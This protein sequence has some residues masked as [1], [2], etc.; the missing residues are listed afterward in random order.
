MQSSDD[1]QMDD[2]NFVLDSPYVNNVYKCT[3]LDE[4][5]F[6]SSYNN[7][8]KFSIMS[9]NIQSL[10][11]KFNDFAELI[12]SLNSHNSAP[13]V[14]CLQELWQFPDS[15]AFS[16][17]GY[18]PLEYKLRRNN[19][20]GGGV[21]IFI[22][23]RLKYSVL[24][25]KSIF[26]DRIFESL[27]IEVELGPSAKC[28]VGSTYRPGTKHP[29]LSSGDQ[30]TQFMDLLSNLCSNLS[31]YKS[32]VYSFGDFNLDLLQYNSS[33]QVTDYIDLLFSF[34][35]MQIITK[36]TR[37]TLKSA[38]L[39]DHLITTSDSNVFESVI[40]TTKLSDH[41]PLIYVSNSQTQEGSNEFYEA[42]NFSY[43]NLEAFGQILQR[44]D[45]N[46]TLTSDCPQEAYTNFANIFFNLYD[47]Q[48]PVQRLKFNRNYHKLENWMSA[49][50]LTSR[51]EKNRLCKIS[52]SEP[53]PF[54]LDKFKHYRNM[55][56]RL[57]RAAKKLYFEIELSLTPKNLGNS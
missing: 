35:F 54:N 4:A 12:H 8:S 5:E 22:K 41:F 26:V 53:S 29:T 16:L 49:G 6:C 38:T 14:I 17:P 33:Q 3:Y 20:Q 18:H 13:D 24:P 32:P 9:L 39:I 19:V 40:L 44:T 30:F 57:I 37:V 25:E 34:G 56:N 11:S 2:D 48:F 21:G 31:D 46:T 27:F 51:R 15:M 7:L 1:T 42:C 23:R 52:L 36:P 28:I 45:W 50:L 47:T 43:S 55:Y 10:Q